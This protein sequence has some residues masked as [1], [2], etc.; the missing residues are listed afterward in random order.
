MKIYNK[1]KPNDV[2]VY[3]AEYETQYE[4]TIPMMNIMFGLG[5]SMYQV[6]KCMKKLKEDWLVEYSYC[7]DMHNPE[8]I[9]GSGYVLT[10]R[11][12]ARASELQERKAGE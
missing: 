5:T 2:L 9:C 3:M 8:K 4:C 11:G 10:G 7:I 6:K 12:E 1:V